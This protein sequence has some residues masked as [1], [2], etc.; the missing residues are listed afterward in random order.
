MTFN[1]N[2][3][4]E[5]YQVFDSLESDLPDNLDELLKSS[6]SHRQIKIRIP[7]AIL[8]ILLIAGG[9]FWG[10]AA[11]QNSEKGSSSPA[12]AF[13]S[14][15]LGAGGGSGASSF[16][17]RFTSGALTTPAASGEVIGIKGNVIYVTTSS[18]ALV[19]ILVSKTTT[20]TKNSEVSISG[21][22]IGDSVSVEGTKTATNTVEAT[23]V[24]AT[25]KGVKTTT[26]PFSP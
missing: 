10:G 17:S 6:K 8:V 3:T 25:A 23:S 14:G 2:K 16:F 19:K 9:A 15:R 26:S 5:I 18:G 24:A 7:T 13:L 21:L 4:D 11:A 20:L 22:T 1:N 12:F